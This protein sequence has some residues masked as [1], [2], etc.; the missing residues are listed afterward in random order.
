MSKKTP[1]MTRT[2]KKHSKSLLCSTPEHN[3][4]VSSPSILDDSSSLYGSEATSP[5]PFLCTQDG[6]HGETDVVWNHYTPKAGHARSPDVRHTPVSRKS[7]RTFKAFTKQVE[8]FP[9]RK[10][11]SKPTAKKS[12]SLKFLRAELL[13]LNEN[14][15]C[16]LQKKE[17]LD[18]DCETEDMFDTSISEQKVDD[19]LMPFVL[20]EKCAKP[21]GRQCLLKNVLSMNCA[22][23]ENDNL[24][25]DD[26]MNECL[27]H[28]SQ[29]IEEYIELKVKPSETKPYIDQI[30][31]DASS[32]EQTRRIA[33]RTLP[34]MKKVESPKL[35][36][37]SFE[38]FLSNINDSDL[39]ILSQLPAKE[40]KQ[41][42]SSKGSSFIFKTGSQHAKKSDERCSNQNGLWTINE[43]IAGQNA[44]SPKTTFTRHNSMPESPVVIQ[45]LK[46]STSG[47]MFG[48]HNSM[49]LNYE[50][51]DNSPPM[52]CTPDEI[53]RKRQLAKEKLLAKRLLPFTA[54]NVSKSLVSSSDCFQVS[55]TKTKFQLKQPSNNASLK[56]IMEKQPIPSVRD[57]DH[58]LRKR[59]HNV[60]HN[61]QHLNGNRSTS[62]PVTDIK[63]IIE[64]KRKE[65]LM[66]LRKK[67]SQ[68]NIPK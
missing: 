13:E 27:M 5:V 21:T 12:E 40:T 45:Q 65:A 48:R 24:E 4:K 25:S 31:A 19:T 60:N 54:P 41:N 55:P 62:N 15:K 59:N 63:M 50:N 3:A 22:N 67:R 52:K 35:N 20:K 51:A 14:V 6:V 2:S 1:S 8:A 58:Q 61:S 47:L 38:T 18:G 26:S 36:N 57:N 68:N 42:P 32:L 10:L 7:K 16:I 33:K 9:T 39:E 11:V 29:M 49:P 23:S 44:P 37:D 28:A 43:S 17:A 64:M 66:K 53:E 30:K 46:P 56:P 34:E